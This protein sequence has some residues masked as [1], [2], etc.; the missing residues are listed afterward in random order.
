M[1]MQGA[2]PT[3]V[4]NPEGIQHWPATPHSAPHLEH[5]GALLGHGL[6][7]GRLKVDRQLAQ[8]VLQGVKLLGRVKVAGGQGVQGRRLLLL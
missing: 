5:A 4:R 1:L 2:G 6:Q 8:L 3:Y 7:L